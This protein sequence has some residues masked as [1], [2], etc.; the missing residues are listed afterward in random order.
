MVGSV[1]TSS[2]SYAG[3]RDNKLTRLLTPVLD[4]SSLTVALIC[5]PPTESQSVSPLFGCDS[6]RSAQHAAPREAVADDSL[7]ASAARHAG[8][9][10]SDPAA[11]GRSVVSST[12][13]GGRPTELRVVRAQL[14]RLGERSTDDLSRSGGRA[15]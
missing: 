4:G 12:T 5:V 9:S 14:E 1:R 10:R 7:G 15:K 3:F 8:R 11:A 2:V 13:A 6:E